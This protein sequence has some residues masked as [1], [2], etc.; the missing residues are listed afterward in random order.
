V[1]ATYA[2]SD[3]LTLACAGG[4]TD[5]SLIAVFV[6][7]LVDLIV[8]V[9]VTALAAVKG[10]SLC[11]AGGLN[12]GFCIFV[13]MTFTGCDESANCQSQEQKT[14]GSC[15]FHNISPSKALYD[16]RIDFNT[17]MI[18]YSIK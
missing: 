6:P 8:V 2:G 12:K 3:S 4:L 7:K 14:K 1:V 13:S 5:H 10:I 16:I 17:Y 9:G 11:N 15:K 18:L